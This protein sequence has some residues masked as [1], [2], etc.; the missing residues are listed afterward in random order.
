MYVIEVIIIGLAHPPEI[1]APA[2]HTCISKVWSAKKRSKMHDASFASYA[3]S[4]QHPGTGSAESSVGVRRAIRGE[5]VEDGGGGSL[6]DWR[7]LMTLET[8]AREKSSVRWCGE[9]HCV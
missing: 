5:M 2:P 6:R 9:I 1:H 4:E 3:L 7:A 8:G